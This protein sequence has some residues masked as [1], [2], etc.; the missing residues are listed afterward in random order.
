LRQRLARHDRRPQA[1]EAVEVIDRRQREVHRRRLPTL[2]DLQVALEVPRG[3]IARSRLDERRGR[4]R[5]TGQPATIRSDVAGVRFSRSS[6]QRRAL[7]ILDVARD[8]L[9][10]VAMTRA[11]LLV[12]GDSAG[13]ATA[14]AG[15]VAGSPDRTGV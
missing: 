12:A 14:T 7:Q 6:R 3:M 2:L 4:L 15:L 9:R 10:D 11:G 5:P 1:E 8:G 13:S